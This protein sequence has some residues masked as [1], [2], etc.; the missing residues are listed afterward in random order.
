MTL[1]SIFAQILPAGSRRFIKLL[2][3][4]LGLFPQINFSLKLIEN[5]ELP[6]DFKESLKQM[7]F[8]APETIE[9][10]L[11]SYLSNDIQ[12]VNKR[13][14]TGAPKPIFICAVKNDIDRVKIQM[15]HHRKIGI[16]YFVYIDNASTDGT[17][18][19]LEM[20]E[21]VTLYKVET[22]FDTA[23]KMGWL[24]SVMKQE[25]YGKWFLILDSDELFAY[26]GMEN[27]H[28]QKYIDF[29]EIKNITTTTTPLIDMYS[30]EEIFSGSPCED[31]RA[32]FC[33]F[34]TFYYQ[35]RGYINWSF[36]GGPRFR[37]F[38][39]KNNLT[40]H[41]L[42]KMEKNMLI[43]IHEIFPSYKNTETGVTAFLLHYKFLSKD[44]N[45]YIEIA[46]N[47]NYFN[48]SEEYKIYIK[49]CKE[50]HDISFYYSGSHKLTNSMDLLRINIADKIF[51][52]E[53]LNWV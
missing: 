15:E 21:D 8:F 17:F 19:W 47:E 30:Q 14:K 20:Q 52:E 7:A 23:T 26:P 31:I 36:W 37:V 33:F 1:I 45:K 32:T 4:R 48:R 42:F 5:V 43:G 34:D 44:I 2:L 3:V 53:F 29:L 24:Q 6:E 25:G 27:I 18:E 50:S 28:I 22:S 40:K 39:L 16:N 13:E 38:S 12:L 46:K 10:F 49:H 41:S 11:K 35:K 51:F 9:K